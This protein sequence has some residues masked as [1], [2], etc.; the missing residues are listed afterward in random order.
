M[1]GATSESQANVLQEVRQ[2][3]DVDALR[4]L[5]PSDLRVAA[6]VPFVPLS[7]RVAEGLLGVGVVV[8]VLSL[9]LWV[10]LGVLGVLLTAGGAG[11]RTLV[12]GAGSALRSR[13]CESWLAMDLGA[14]QLVE[15]SLGIEDVR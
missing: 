6:L 3:P 8:V 11:Q 5:R 1:Q 4:V 15:A 7:G 10:L 2:R 12:L 13:R 14:S 9:E